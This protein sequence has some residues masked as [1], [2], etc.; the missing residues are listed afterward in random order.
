M[1]AIVVY[2]EP[3]MIFHPLGF[4]ARSYCLFQLQD[5]DIC[6]LGKLIPAVQAL[7]SPY[8]LQKGEQ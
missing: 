3:F 6:I 7:V 5:T 4:Y 1:W 8:F 2:Y